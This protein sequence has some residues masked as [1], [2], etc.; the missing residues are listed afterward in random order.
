[1]QMVEEHLRSLKFCTCTQPSAWHGKI[2]SS[3]MQSRDEHLG[4]FEVS[5]FFFF[6]FFTWQSPSPLG[7]SR[8]DKSLTRSELKL[9]FD[10]VNV[11]GSQHQG[12]IGRIGA[13]LSVESRIREGI[14]DYRAWIFTKACLSIQK[15]LHGLFFGLAPPS[16]RRFPSD[17]A[18]PP[19]SFHHFSHFAFQAALCLH[20]CHSS[21]FVLF[22]HSQS[23]LSS[24]FFF[25][26]P[27]SLD[28]F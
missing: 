22:T 17:L 13:N 1:M 16:A 11:S 25:P 5:S 21:L 14:D 18:L 7:V 23:P 3:Q 15:R 8:R 20:G 2:G 27:Q 10:Q 12:L 19:V 28:W 6:F 9:L 26:L 24:F 4:Q